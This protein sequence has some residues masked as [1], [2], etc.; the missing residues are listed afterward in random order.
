[1]TLGV[2]AAYR[3][4]KIGSR[5][6]QHALNEASRDEYIKD[7]YLHVQTNNEQAFAFY[8][9]FGFVKGEVL[10]NYYKRI[11]PPDAVVLSRNLR[12][13]VIEDVEGVEYPTAADE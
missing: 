7:A 11:E 1:M 5:L 3:D 4:G 10:K 8:D 12:D 13:W 9:R 6:L 2:Y